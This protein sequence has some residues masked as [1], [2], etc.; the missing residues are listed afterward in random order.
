MF[1]TNLM[2]NYSIGSFS[3]G[4]KWSNL[5]NLQYKKGE[6]KMNVIG[7]VVEHKSLGR[8]IYRS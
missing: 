2:Y 5:Y 8:V 3:S 7:Q 1:L 4:R 6:D